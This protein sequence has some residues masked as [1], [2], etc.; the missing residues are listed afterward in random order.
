MST[1][2]YL[3]RHG[4]AAESWDQALDPG[5]SERGVTQAHEMAVRLDAEI[6]PANLYSSPLNRTQDTAQPLA[7]L[8]QVGAIIAPELAEVPS[9]GLDLGNRRAWLTNVL[10]GVW[11]EQ[12]EH[13]RTWRST[14]LD[15]IAKQMQDAVFVT[16]FVVIN[17]IVGALEGRDDVIVFRPDH[18]SITKISI[19]GGTMSLIEKGQEAVTV[20][21]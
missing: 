16:H 4:E 13:L 11:S 1:T 21:K 18:C 8:W 17:A 3:V 15:F 5:L 12:S 14:I 19:S 6:A 9:A 2:I 10:E 20:I 7:D